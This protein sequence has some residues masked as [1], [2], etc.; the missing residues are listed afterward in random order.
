MIIVAGLE[1]GEILAMAEKV[2]VHIAG[3]CPE[4]GNPALMAPED[5][6]ADTVVTCLKCDYKAQWK[7]VFGARWKNVFGE[8]K[9]DH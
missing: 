8:D 1:T 4:C 5:Y 7:N 9:A 6:T 2:T 3:G